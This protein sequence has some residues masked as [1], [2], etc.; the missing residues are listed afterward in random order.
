M[1]LS[2]CR[3][4]AHLSKE[5]VAELVA[6]HPHA[7]DLVTSWLNHNG[8]PSSSIST[9]F[10]GGWL[11]ITDVP[12]SQANR[13]L[14]ASYQLYGQAGTNDTTILRTVGYSLPAV[15]HRHVQTVVP[16]T[17]FATTRAP[18]LW[19]TPRGRSVGEP[20][21]PANAGLA[22]PGNVTSAHTGSRESEL[23]V[24]SKRDVRILPARLRSL[25][26][27]TTYIPA[28]IDENKLGVA[29]YL[30]QYPSP[31]DLRT[32]MWDYR[33]D[34]VAAAYTV[35]QINGGDY[36]MSHPGTEAN[37]DMQYAQAMAFPTPH[38][39]YC[40]GG[41]IKRGPAGE[42]PAQGD[43][44]LEWLKYMLDDKK[45]KPIPQTI[46]TSYIAAERDLPREYTKALCDMYS[47]LGALGVSILFASGDSGVGP[48]NCDDGSGNV[49]F[50]PEFPASCMCGVL[51]SNAQ[52]A[53]TIPSRS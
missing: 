34:A 4:G 11:T 7:L 16:T 2:R 21:A 32:F 49:Q 40:T 27:T 6:P 24:L 33:D 5:Q 8:V 26:K 25:Y 23:T 35:E 30:G 12:V 3:Y 17:C 45:D 10:G 38:I 46:S 48:K 51:S 52:N 42:G 50:V 29:G 53:C 18:R 1:P 9:T 19:K 14:G 44:F 13:L 37:V 20:G 36:E 15:L 31:T 41:K 43:M 47:R 28:A 22:G 39:F